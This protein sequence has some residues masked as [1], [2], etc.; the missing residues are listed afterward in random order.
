LF[1][2]LRLNQEL[3]EMLA[4]DAAR[5]QRRAAKQGRRHEE[6]TEKQRI[7]AWVEGGYGRRL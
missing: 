1:E 6:L 7:D 5:R 3:E 4:W 2:Q